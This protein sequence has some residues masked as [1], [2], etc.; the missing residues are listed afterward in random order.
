MKSVAETIVE[1]ILDD[2]MGRSGFGNVWDEMTDEDQKRLTSDLERI[3][4]K[5]A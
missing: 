4:G 5:Y 1:K 2:L 3:V